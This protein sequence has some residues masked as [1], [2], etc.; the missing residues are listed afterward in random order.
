[1][2]HRA[3]ITLLGSLVGLAL[4]GATSFASAQPSIDGNDVPSMRVSYRDLD[5]NDSAG[6]TALLGRIRHAAETLCEPLK[7]DDPPFG[8]WGYRRCVRQA[9]GR[10]VSELNNPV[11]DALANPPSVR[12]TRLAVGGR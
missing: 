10:A 5:I 4:A 11:V 8:V 3:H 1:M 9:V 2:Q 12:T 7:D 6:A